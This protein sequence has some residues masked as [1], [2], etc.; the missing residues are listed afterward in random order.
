MA[1]L[2]R[3]PLPLPNRLAGK[4]PGIAHRR[5]L[6]ASVLALVV[7]VALLQVNQFSRV[8]STGYQINDLNRER[9]RKQAE[10]HQIEADVARLTSLARVDIEA[11]VRLA[12]V[13]AERKL[14]ISVS[15]PVPGRETLPT[16]FLPIERPPAAIMP[17]APHPWWRRGLKLL[18]FS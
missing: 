8:T 1:V 2:Q 6:V 4:L 13:P 16:R 12:M 10:N 15:Q 17:P 5:L 9:A 11:R 7:V 3:P 18:P 14:S